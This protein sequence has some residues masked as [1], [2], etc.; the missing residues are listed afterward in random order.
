[1]IEY[2]IILNKVNDTY[3]VL[4]LWSHTEARKILIEKYKSFGIKELNYEPA[5]FVSG[6]PKFVWVRQKY[7]GSYIKN[8]LILSTKFLI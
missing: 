5:I 2:I 7:S 1:M 6:E 8:T 4:E 3:S